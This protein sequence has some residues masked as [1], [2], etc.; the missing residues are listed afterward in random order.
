MCLEDCVDKN[1][2]AA[3][4]DGAVV[5]ANDRVDLDEQ[6]SGIEAL[7]D[8]AVDDAFVPNIALINVDENAR[9]AVGSVQ[10]GDALEY[11]EP[12]AGTND[13]L[14]MINSSNV[15]TIFD[16]N[17]FDDDDHSDRG[18]NYVDLEFPDH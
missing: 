3:D 2:E 10:A 16:N 13:E 4:V 18:N 14:D 7:A 11:T 6:N 1:N 9:I 8:V 17:N 15:G 5:G 12:A